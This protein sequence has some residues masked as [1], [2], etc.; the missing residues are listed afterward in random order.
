MWKWIFDFVV[1]VL[2]RYIIL[3][4]ISMGF[5]GFVEAHQKVIWITLGIVGVVLSFELPEI[6]RC[7]YEEWKKQDLN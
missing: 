7:I 4:I 3:A 1:L 5:W 6:W 2:F